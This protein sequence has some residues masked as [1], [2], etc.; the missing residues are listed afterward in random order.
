[1][2]S[3]QVIPFTRQFNSFRANEAVRSSG[4]ASQANT[5]RGSTKHRLPSARDDSAT[6]ASLTPRLCRRQQN[7]VT[8]SKLS[9]KSSPLLSPQIIRSTRIDSNWNKRVVTKGSSIHSKSPGSSGTSVESIVPK[10][11]QNLSTSMYNGNGGGPQKRAYNNSG[12]LVAN[13]MINSTRS[14]ALNLNNNNKMPSNST[15]GH[16][17]HSNNNNNKLS[18]KS[19]ENNYTSYS[20]KYPNGLP[21]EDEFYHR[22]R[23]S[24][25]ETSSNTVSSSDSDSRNFR[26]EDDEFSRKPSNEALYVDFTKSFHNNESKLS[27]TN[28]LR[29]TQQ[30][31]SAQVTKSSNPLSEYNRRINGV[32][33]SCT[34]HIYK[35]PAMILENVVPKKAA[36]ASIVNKLQHHHVKNSISS[37]NNN[38]Y[39][40][41][42]PSYLVSPITSWVP[43]SKQPITTIIPDDD[44]DE[45]N[46]SDIESSETETDDECSSLTNRSN[47]EG[48]YHL[49]QKIALE[50]TMNGKT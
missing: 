7:S 6:K 44:E 30:A 15:N 27:T 8:S 34:S 10:Y 49:K 1:M 4:N 43:K 21:F 36:S 14:A 47:S 26:F 25:S 16:I 41:V 11:S 42:K 38:N 35:N 33:S 32:H 48:D 9:M 40:A 20:S 24:L 50:P 39:K 29:R 22:R 5:T 37:A 13:K 23:K 17:T 2:S 46:L 18:V 3:G 31:M 28:R 12:K 45:E 19:K